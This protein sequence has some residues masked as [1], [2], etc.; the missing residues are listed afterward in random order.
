MWPEGPVS[1]APSSVAHTHLPHLAHLQLAASNQQPATRN[2]Q[3]EAAVIEF[4]ALEL[5]WLVILYF[6]FSILFSASCI[7]HLFNFISRSAARQ[8]STDGKITAPSQVPLHKSS[9]LLS[10]HWQKFQGGVLAKGCIH[11]Q[12][13]QRINKSKFWGETIWKVNKY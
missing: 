2:L 13:K 8:S 12:N 5:E 9:Y 1:S 3:P 11:N 6:V 7:L 4:R 10:L